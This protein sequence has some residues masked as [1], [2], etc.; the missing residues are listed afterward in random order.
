MRK[1][2]ISFWRFFG[3]FIRTIGNFSQL[4]GYVVQGIGNLIEAV[5]G[6]VGKLLN[7]FCDKIDAKIEEAPKKGKFE[8]N[9]EPTEN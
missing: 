8:E 4:L 7:K 6:F 2:L 5:L 3:M 9:R 1:I